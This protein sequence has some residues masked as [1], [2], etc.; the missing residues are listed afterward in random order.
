[1]ER[2][3]F[4]L[5]N[6][7]PGKIEKGVGMA[8]VNADRKGDM[9]MRP[10]GFSREASQTDGPLPTDLPVMMREDA[11]MPESV[12]WFQAAWI[13]RWHESSFG[14]PVESPYPR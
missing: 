5:G 8:A 9:R 3:R 7:S 10:H 1:M 4:M 2:M 13:A 6:L 14:V 12:R 11:G